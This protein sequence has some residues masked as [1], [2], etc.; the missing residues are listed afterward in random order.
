MPPISKKTFGLFFPPGSTRSDLQAASNI[1][2][3]LRHFFGWIRLLARRKVQLEL[4]I[5]PMALAGSHGHAG[6]AACP[7]RSAR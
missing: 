1:R 2:Q 5:F 4:R 3:N 6:P 7:R